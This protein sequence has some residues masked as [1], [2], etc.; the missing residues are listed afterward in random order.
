[1]LLHPAAMM[2]S[3]PSQPHVLHLIAAILLPSCDRQPHD[4][5]ITDA[6]HIMQ[7]RGSWMSRNTHLLKNTPR[8][9][10]PLLTETPLSATFDFFPRWKASIRSLQRGSALNELFHLVKGGVKQEGMMPRRRSRSRLCCLCSETPKLE[11]TYG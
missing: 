2:S 9:A 4:R 8:K 11:Y 10:R 7:K 5:V 1:M 3:R 6:V